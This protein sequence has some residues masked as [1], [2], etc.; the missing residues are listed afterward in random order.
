MQ[1]DSESIINAALQLPEAERFLIISRLLESTPKPPGF[2][3]VDD[4]ELEAEL[5]RRFADQDG[6]VPWSKLSSGG[7]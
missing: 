4:P 1:L 3:S 2:I 5:D 7:Q 6:A